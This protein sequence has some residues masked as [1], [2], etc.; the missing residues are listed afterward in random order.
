MPIYGSWTGSTTFPGDISIDEFGPDRVVFFQNDWF[1]AA[2]GTGITR[3]ETYERVRP[4]YDPLDPPVKFGAS[5]SNVESPYSG[6]VGYGLSLYEL[7]LSA[8]GDLAGWILPDGDT[9][10]FRFKYTEAD[11]VAVVT[12]TFMRANGGY[13]SDPGAFTE[14]LEF[15]WLTSSELADNLIVLDA[16]V[17]G[18]QRYR[19]WI[20]ITGAD[21]PTADGFFGDTNSTDYGIAFDYVLGYVPVT[22]PDKSITLSD[23]TPTEKY[24]LY[25]W[26]ASM[27]SGNGPIYSNFASLSFFDTRLH[28]TKTT[29]NWRNVYA[30]QAAA[31]VITLVQDPASMSFLNITWLYVDHEEPITGWEISVDGISNVLFSETP[32]IYSFPVDDNTTTPCVVQV[33]ALDAYGYGLWGEASIDLVFIQ[34]ALRMLQRDDGLGIVGHARIINNSDQGRSA[35][36]RQYGQRIGERQTYS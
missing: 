20:E 14:M 17:G 30:T 5:L 36:S 4:A 27:K 18:I 31:P 23:S 10:G 25:T 3:S 32:R 28:Y 26:P 21:L 16:L 29:P 2:F 35:T 12:D 15:K 34:P 13:F 11:G 24:Y 19:P 1:I 22:A 33:R 6:I 8:A 7:D 9:S